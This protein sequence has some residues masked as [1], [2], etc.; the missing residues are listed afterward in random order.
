MDLINKRTVLLVQAMLTSTSETIESIGRNLNIGEASQFTKFF[1]KHT[2]QT[3]NEYC[4][5][6]Q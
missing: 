6:M 4:K 1:K 2:G 5:S 3:P